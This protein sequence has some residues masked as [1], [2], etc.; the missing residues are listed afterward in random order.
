MISIVI[1]T[2]VWNGNEI[3]N[4]VGWTGIV[5]VIVGDH[6]F[7]ILIQNRNGH[8]PVVEV[9]R[10]DD[11]HG[12]HVRLMRMMRM[13]MLM[14]MLQHYDVV[15]ELMFPM[16]VTWLLQRYFVVDTHVYDHDGDER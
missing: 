6:E 4:H 5:N 9:V 8:V 13:L 2:D 15:H 11:P 14:L 1:V 10:S 7:S 16:V 3:V 12:H